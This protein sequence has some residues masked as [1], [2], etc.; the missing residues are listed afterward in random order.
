[1]LLGTYAGTLPAPPPVSPGFSATLESVW[2]LSPN[3]NDPRPLPVLP[4]AG[5]PM[6][7]RDLHFPFPVQGNDRPA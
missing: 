5:G 4:G 2:E 7:A 1:M 3:P 6:V